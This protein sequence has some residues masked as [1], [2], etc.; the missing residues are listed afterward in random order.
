MK[1]FLKYLCLFLGVILPLATIANPHGTVIFKHPEK[2]NELWETNLENTNKARRIYRH[3]EEIWEFAVQE[4]G[5]LI[6][7]VSDTD[8]FTDIYLFNSTRSDIEARNLTRGLFDEIVSI[9]MSASGDIIFANAMGGRPNPP[10][11]GIYLIRKQQLEKRFPKAT[12]LVEDGVSHVAWSPMSKMIVFASSETRK[13]V[14]T[15]DIEA[16]KFSDI[17]F[18][19]STPIF[20]PNG[21]KVAYYS[22]HGIISIVSLSDLNDEDRIVL[23][24][25]GIW[26]LKWSPDG[27]YIFCKTHGDTFGVPVNGGRPVKIF[28]Q[29]DRGVSFDWVNS[30]KSF[31]VEPIGRLTTLWGKLKR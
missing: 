25:T 31:S 17:G 6:V 1:Y 27:Q 10:K 30:S 19:G 2:L 15:F 29:F 22:G 9:D 5:S 14:Y 28:E 20:S 24:Q 7:F 11:E 12:L 16:P 18:G 13:G 8:R 3:T 4:E 26:K 21:K 23:E